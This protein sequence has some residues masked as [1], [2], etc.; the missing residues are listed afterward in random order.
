MVTS[1]CPGRDA[2][3]ASDDSVLTWWQPQLDDN[4]PC[5]TFV[6]GKKTSYRIE[7]YRIIWRDINMEVLDGIMPGPFQYLVEYTGDPEAREWKVLVNASGNQKDLCIDY[8][9]FEPVE[10]YSV[11]LRIT[12][13]PE[14]IEPGV[15]SFTVFGRCVHVCK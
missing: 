1:N 2:I 14:N 6:L 10:A 5:I 3:Y 9:Q 7:S 12:G 11:R 15:V 8:R 4:E 13:S